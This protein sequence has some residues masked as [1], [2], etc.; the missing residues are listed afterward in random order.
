MQNKMDKK[1][2]WV[3]LTRVCI[4]SS[5]PSSTQEALTS[6][7]SSPDNPSGGPVSTE[8]QHP[9]VWLVQEE[10]KWTRQS[11][12]FWISADWEV[13]KAARSKVW[14]ASCQLVSGAGGSVS[15]EVQWLWGGTAAESHGNKTTLYI[16]SLAWMSSCGVLFIYS[17]LLFVADGACNPILLPTD[18]A[19]TFPLCSFRRPSENAV[20]RQ[21]VIF[22]EEICLSRL[23]KKE[24]NHSDS[25]Q[26]FSTTPVVFLFM[27]CRLIHL[28]LEKKRQFLW[29]CIYVSAKLSSKQEVFAFWSLPE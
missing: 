10:T 12:L 15:P 2:T 18:G 19:S 22:F 8:T 23:T 7:L 14:S 24:E 3:C 6:L 4:Y 27:R 11:S 5:S 9:P 20:K 29:T 1:E 16:Q 25:S 17:V 28:L 21:T 13:S 26:V